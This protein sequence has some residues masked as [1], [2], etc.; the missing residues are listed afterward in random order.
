MQLPKRKYTSLLGIA[1]PL[2]FMGAGITQAQD[3]PADT[4]FLQKAVQHALAIYET[5]VGVQTHLYNGTEYIDYKKPHFEGDQFFVSKAAA[6]GNI[7]YDGAWH[8]GVPMIY[9][10]VTDEVVVPHNSSGLLLKL[11]T[12]KI[13]TFQLHGHTFVRLEADS[14]NE[15]ALQPG[16]YDLLHSGDNQF[17]I[18]RSRNMQDKATPTG[19]E[20]EFRVGDK[21]YIR[22]DGNYYEVNS[23]RSVYKV[24]KE[25][26]KQL[27]QYARSK[28]LKFRKQREEAI[29]ALTRYYDSLSAEQPERSNN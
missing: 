10:I 6:R 9:D 29:L 28:R 16:F 15:E 21:F 1:L 27:Q 24:F 18:R 20:G 5:G 17:L 11:I 19:M 12:S 7:F 2:Y 8:T 26:K 4:V 14:A 3:F 22:K 25:R 23:K 13:D